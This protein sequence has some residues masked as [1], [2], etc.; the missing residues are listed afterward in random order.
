MKK[1]F[2]VYDSKAEA[3][4]QPFFTDSTGLAIRAFETAANNEKHEFNRYAGDYTLFEIGIYDEQTAELEALTQYINLGLALE[5][6]QN[7]FARS[8]QPEHPQATGQVANTN[9]KEA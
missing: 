8:S 3:Y 9:L 2:S 4:L 6:I 7:D 5:M 1:V